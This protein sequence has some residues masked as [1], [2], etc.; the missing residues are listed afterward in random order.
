MS[1]KKPTGSCLR[2]PVGISNLCDAPLNSLIAQ[3]QF[4][5]QEE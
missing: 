1:T 4:V 3:Q 5:T 2:M